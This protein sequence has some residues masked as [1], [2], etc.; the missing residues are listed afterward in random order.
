MIRE[1]FFQADFG[2]PLYFLIPPPLYVS[3]PYLKTHM[4][5]EKLKNCQ[6]N[7]ISICKTNR[8]RFPSIN[9]KEGSKES[10]SREDRHRKF[11]EDTNE[12][13]ERSNQDHQKGTY[14]RP[15]I[16]QLDPEHTTIYIYSHFFVS[17]KW[18]SDFFKNSF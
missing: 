3:L 9:H 4:R 7:L 16:W 18:I 2:Y 11:S 6:R 13:R 5:P 1:G 8:T 14:R 17:R 12:I 15:G 10:R